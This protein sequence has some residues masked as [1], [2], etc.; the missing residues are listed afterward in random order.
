MLHNG[1]TSSFIKPHNLYASYK[2]DQSKT[3]TSINAFDVRT[4]D[5]LSSISYIGDS[6]LVYASATSIYISAFSYSQF[7]D[8]FSFD[9]HTAIYKFNLDNHLTYNANGLV[10]GHLLSQ[11]SMSEHN[12][13]LR[14]A[15]T[16][17]QTC[18]I[19]DNIIFTLQEHNGTLYTIGELKG[20]GE[21][22]ETIR[23][24]RFMGEKAFIVTFLQIDPFY[25]IDL[26]DP[27]E[28]RVIG[29]LK[30]NG[31]SEYLH[32]VDENHILSIGRYG[33]AGGTI[34]G[35][36]IQL[37]DVSDFSMPF[38]IDKITL[39]NDLTLSSIETIPRAF[40]YRE[41]D[42]LFGIPI[43]SRSSYG[44]KAFDVYQIHN[45]SIMPIHTLTMDQDAKSRYNHEQRGII[46]DYNGLTYATMF[47]EDHAI[48][49]FLSTYSSQIKV[50]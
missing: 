21:F 34:G 14:L 46:F 30:I 15:T 12:E 39:G 50:K 42:M 11:Y 35:L 22:G 36:Q 27:M 5:P 1:N 7:F 37:Y 24:V 16:I 41:K 13:T 8:F 28:P 45:S 48:T 40:A 19:I 44:D 2:L 3:I 20:L 29:E 26:S 4:G 18:C 49:Q 31:F 6:H 47:F 43:S 33:D 10:K 23:A 17:S 25:T 32:P 9:E 38:L